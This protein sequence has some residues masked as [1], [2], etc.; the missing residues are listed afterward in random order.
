MK[1]ADNLDILNREQLIAYINDLEARLGEV[2]PKHDDVSIVMGAYKLTAQE[3]RMLLALQAGR[4][5]PINH[6]RMV[7]A[8]SASCI[9]TGGNLAAVVVS[10]L[11]KKLSPRGFSI[12][13]VWGVGYRLTAGV[14]ELADALEMGRFE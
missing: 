3:A 6:L 1:F 14:S 2:A 11:R 9:E 4:A 10:K 8:Q 7:C 12:E 13:N 5:V